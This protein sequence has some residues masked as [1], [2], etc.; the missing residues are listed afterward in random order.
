MQV[1]AVA[2]ARGPPPSPP[3]EE[4]E[5]EEEAV[6]VRARWSPWSDEE[7]RSIRFLPRC[8]WF[9]A[10]VEFHSQLLLSGRS[11][12]RGRE[13]TRSEVAQR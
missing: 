12:A 1:A 2:V 9:E 11:V 10:V 13:P 5:E 7:V 4:E 8:V 6:V 3:P